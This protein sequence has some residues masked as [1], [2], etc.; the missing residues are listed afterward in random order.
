MTAAPARLARARCGA[1]L[2]LL[3]LGV[4]ACATRPPAVAP[5]LPPDAGRAVELDGTPFFPQARYQCGPAAL[6]TVLGASGVP[7]TDE[8]L[9][10]LVYLPGRRG[11]LQA[12]LVAATRA[13]DRVPYVL[14]ASLGAVLAEVAHGR[15]VLVLQNLGTER[16]PAWHFAVVNGF[17][18]QADTV[19]LRSGPRAREVMSAHR[20]DASWARAQRWA[21]VVLRPGELPVA[22]VRERYLEAAAGLEA[23]GRLEAALA[24]Y[25]AATVRWPGDALAAFGIANVRHRQGRLDDAIAGY[26]R[27]IAAEPANVLARNNLAHVL[28]DQGCRTAALEEV[29]EALRMTTDAGLLGI[30]RDT[31]R[32]LR[33]GD[34]STAEEPASCLRWRTRP[35]SGQRSGIPRVAAPFAL[36]GADCTGAHAVACAT[37]LPGSTAEARAHSAGARHLPLTRRHIDSASRVVQAGPARG[38]LRLLSDLAR[39]V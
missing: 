3:A 19:V 5:A 1:S 35:S 14:D 38:K 22:P 37:G 32:E 20:F 7:V 25:E 16:F 31:E 2:V 28:A 9:V 15:P 21:M 36:A 39:F 27:V 34:A 10:P 4:S 23:T 8:E 24:A 26:R 6:A 29:A 33:A 12:E 18:A 13:F 17:D 30:L 11:S